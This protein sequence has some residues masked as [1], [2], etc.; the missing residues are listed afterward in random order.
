MSVLLV[1]TCSLMP[2]SSNLYVLTFVLHYL[3]MF[4]LVQCTNRRLL[5]ANCECEKLRSSTQVSALVRKNEYC[6]V[7]RFVPC[8]S[9]LD[10]IDYSRHVLDLDKYV[11]SDCFSEFH[12]TN[13]NKRTKHL[14]GWIL[15]TFS[16]RD[17]L[18]MV[19]LFNTQMSHILNIVPIGTIK[20]HFFIIIIT[21]IERSLRGHKFLYY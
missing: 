2:K 9:S 5:L 3:V 8:S 10:I 6:P 7:I 18:T 11:L 15:R 21:P 1:I 16:S 14:T 4:T 13:H 20:M 12:I 17:K 19:T